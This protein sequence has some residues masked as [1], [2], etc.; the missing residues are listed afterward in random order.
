MVFRLAD[1]QEFSEHNNTSHWAAPHLTCLLRLQTMHG[2]RP[3][4]LHGCLPRNTFELRFYK[5]V[6]AALGF[7]NTFTALW[8]QQGRVSDWANDWITN[9]RRSTKHRRVCFTVAV[10]FQ[11]VQDRRC[12]KKRQCLLCNWDSISSFLVISVL[13]FENA[14]IYTHAYLHP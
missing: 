2:S 8:L 5:V 1:V 3:T 11:C 4:N 13:Y 10:L 12:C 9:F 7:C 6:P 14:H